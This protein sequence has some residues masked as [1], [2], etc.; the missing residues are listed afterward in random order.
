MANTDNP[1]NCLINEFLQGDSC[2]PC[3][4]QIKGCYECLSN[5]CLLCYPSYKLYQEQSTQS[6]IC[7][8]SSVECQVYSKI[9]NPK[10][11]KVDVCVKLKDSQ[12]GLIIGLCA[13]APVL[14]IVVLIAVRV[15]YSSSVRQTV[16]RRLDPI[17]KKT[18]PT[19]SLCND[20]K[21]FT[22][23]RKQLTNVDLRATNVRKDQFTPE[24]LNPELRRRAK[25]VPCGGFVCADCERGFLKACLAGRYPRCLHCQE[26]VL[27]F[28]ED[29]MEDLEASQKVDVSCT[30]AD[31]I[32]E[33]LCVICFKGGLECAIPC[34]NKPRH[35]LHRK[36]LAYM[37]Q[38]KNIGEV[39]CP[40]CRTGVLF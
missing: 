21:A 12:F 8:S 10:N 24:V 35:L 30:S 31:R 9:E 39:K 2:R 37:L 15:Y 5:H 23:P 28:Q 29:L 16:K 32:R 40:I 3:E 36:C 7:V 33:D 18:H 22:R 27:F 20:Q 13:L 25:M 38:G 4:T 34:E 17:T 26:R 6:L 1:T 11:E 19:C 14:V